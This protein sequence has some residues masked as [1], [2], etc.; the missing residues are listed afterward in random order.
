MTILKVLKKIPKMDQTLGHQKKA[1][2]R[3]TNIC[4]LYGM[5]R[6]Q[7]RVLNHKLLLKDTLLMSISN[8]PKIVDLTYSF[9]E[10]WLKTKNFNVETFIYSKMLSNIKK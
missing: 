9:L 5:E 3:N 2:D 6:I 10:V 1:L 7:E 8:K 4:S